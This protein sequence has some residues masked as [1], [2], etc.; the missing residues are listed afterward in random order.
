M[1]RC[2]GSSGLTFIENQLDIR[3]RLGGASK[4][5]GLS[6]GATSDQS[7]VHLHQSAVGRLGVRPGR[8]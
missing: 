3:S 7:Q 8:G 5:P 4:G 1:S 2:F 6:P